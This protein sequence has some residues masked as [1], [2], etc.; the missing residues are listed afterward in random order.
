LLGL[1]KVTFNNRFLDIFIDRMVR[2]Q[3]LNRICR[4][5]YNFIKI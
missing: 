2:D 4:V 3:T 1:D 5:T